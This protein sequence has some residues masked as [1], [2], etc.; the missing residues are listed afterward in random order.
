MT[1]RQECPVAIPLAMSMV[2]P[3]L[4]NGATLTTYG[5]DV[6]C[7]DGLFHTRKIVV[8][9]DE[10]LADPRRWYIVCLCSG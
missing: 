5:I 8:Y 2:V 3:I 9:G 4:E 6:K 10:K 1:N 7:A